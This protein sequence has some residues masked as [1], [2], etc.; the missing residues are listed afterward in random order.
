MKHKKIKLSTLLLCLGLF[1][2]QAQD[3]IPT[4]GGNALGS[5]GTASYSVGQVVY[6]TNTSSSGSVSQGV[7]QPYDISVVNSV[8]QAKGISL[9]CTAYPNPTTDKLILKFDASS[10]LSIQLLNYQLF[11]ISGKLIQHQKIE[12]NQTSISMDGLFSATY[13]LKI[14]DNNKEIK[15]FKIIK[16]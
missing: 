8:E 7:Q 5:R 11:D 9:Q 12:S 2:I 16:K 15:T 10:V 1:G 6:T 13:F 3:A 4:T 14:T